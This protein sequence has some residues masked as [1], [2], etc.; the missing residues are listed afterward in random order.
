MGKV[1][2]IY[3]ECSPAPPKIKTNEARDKKEKRNRLTYSTDSNLTWSHKSQAADRMFSQKHLCIHPY[4]F[5]FVL[6]SWSQ[7]PPAT[8]LHSAS[9][10]RNNHFG[11]VGTFATFDDSKRITY[12]SWSINFTWSTQFLDRSRPRPPSRRLCFV[13]LTSQMIESATDPVLKPE[14]H[15]LGNGLFWEWM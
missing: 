3:T 9:F 5:F 10:Y 13:Q 4:L 6:V 2:H 15:F 8:L 1:C 14:I 11:V 7:S 12:G